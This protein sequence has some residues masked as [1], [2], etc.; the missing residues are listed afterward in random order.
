MAFFNEFPHTRTYD[1]DL[2]WLIK[3]VK[4]YSE[5]LEALDE[6]KDE[7]EAW[8]DEVI[9]EIG[10]LQDLPEQFEAF[11]ET[12]DDEF[13]AFR[14]QINNDFDL[15]TRNLDNKIDTAIQ[16][17]END[18][19]DYKI[20]L[21]LEINRKI[22]ELYGVIDANN[23]FLKA[24]M[25]TKLQ[26][27]IDSLPEYT[28]ENIFVYNPVTGSTDSLQHTLIDIYDAGRLYGLTAA[29]YD[30]LGLTATE[31]DD[32]ELTA[33][34]YDTY[35][36][37]LLSFIP[38][39]NEIISPFTGEKTTTQAVIYQLADLHKDALT[40][41]E[42]DAKDLTADEYDQLNLT[43]YDYDWNGKTLIA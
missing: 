17:M 15:L 42:Y 4:S 22:A 24:Y 23:D 40:A 36:K 3:E 10:T 2:G 29:E 31:Y 6:F 26:E 1:S 30:Q 8:K 14:I 9:E 18:L 28:A 19:N 41:S 21:T 7:I 32:L 27:F 5:Q 20:A 38:K 33:Y 43:A 35:G 34:E 11:Q 39:C 37:E 16:Q 13:T 12:I 25:E